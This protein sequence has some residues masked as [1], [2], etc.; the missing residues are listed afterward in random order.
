MEFDNNYQV[1]NG[2]NS[3]KALSF[4][5]DILDIFVPALV[6][7]SLIF[8]FFFRTAQVEGE[9]MLDTLQNND[10]LIV[11]NFVYQPNYGD[12]VI[13]NRYHPGDEV[14]DV[15]LIKRVIGLPGDVV[16]VEPDCV[17]L[18][19]VKIDEPYIH[20]TNNPCGVYTVPDGEVFA[21]G[22]HRNYSSDSR[23]FGTF[24]FEDIEG[25]AVFRYAP[26]MGNVY[27]NMK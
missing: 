16:R 7:V 6:L 24:K 8:M 14:P 2:Q 17:Y 13:V 18:N 21:M 11:S 5:Y 20:Y 25:K 27:A 9:S 4:V 10:R 23:Y 19:D 26:S 15:P 3:L 12:I 22:D 1:N